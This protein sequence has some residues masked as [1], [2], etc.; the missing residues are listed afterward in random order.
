VLHIE[1][2]PHAGWTEQ[3]VGVPE[4]TEAGARFDPAYRHF[5]RTASGG[6]KLEQF[7]P[8]DTVSAAEAKAKQGRRICHEERRTVERAF[9][10]LFFVALVEPDTVQPGVLSYRS[11]IVNKHSNQVIGS[12]TEYTPERFIDIYERLLAKSQAEGQN[13]CLTMSLPFPWKRSGRQPLATK[14]KEMGLYELK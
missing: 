13:W 14:A 8:A 1:Q 5:P 3:R 11:I 12:S 6:P 10:W 2:V 4:L 9:G 7:N